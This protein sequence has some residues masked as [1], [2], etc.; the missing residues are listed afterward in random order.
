MQDNFLFSR[1]HV[2][3]KPREEGVLVVGIS[4]FAQDQ[5]GEILFVELPTIG[6]ELKQGTVLSI[7][8]S[9]KSASEVYMPL[10]GKVLEVNTE[11]GDSPEYVNQDPFG[12]GWIAVI[13]ISNPNQ[14]NQLL[15]SKTYQEFIDSL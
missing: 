10:D 15:D 8:E 1:E 5:L 6:K 11:L 7:V 12:N 14:L 4:S 2:W 3:V 9:V 13:G